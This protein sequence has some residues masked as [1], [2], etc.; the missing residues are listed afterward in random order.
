MDLGTG[1]DALMDSGTGLDALK[2]KI[3]PLPEIDPRF[4]VCQ[5]SRIITVSTGLSCLT[6]EHN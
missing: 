5:A 4:P 3:L 2:K 1:L 6:T